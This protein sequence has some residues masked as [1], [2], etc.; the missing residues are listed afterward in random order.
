MASVPSG[1]SSDSGVV[2]NDSLVGFLSRLRSIVDS[3]TKLHVTSGIRTA[4]SQASALSTKRS[5]GDDLYKLYARDDLIK[6][7][8]SVPNN[9]SDMARVINAQIARGQFLSNHMSG[10]ALDL[11]SRDWTSA[12]TASVMAAA[13]SLSVEANLETTPPHLHLEGIGGTFAQVSQAVSAL[14]S[15]EVAA[16]VA[17]G[18]LTPAQVLRNVPWWGWAAF[19]GLLVV[20]YVGISRSGD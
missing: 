13:R 8:L 20:T 9:V 4:E 15:G 14:S 18:K 3:S 2:L 10:K 7:I 5:L 19:G 16:A 1:V 11:R 12:Q 17:A 6:E